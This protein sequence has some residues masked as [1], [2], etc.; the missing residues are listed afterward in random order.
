M[1]PPASTRHSSEGQ[2]RRRVSGLTPMPM[3]RHGAAAVLSAAA[4]RSSF[5]RTEVRLLGATQGVSTQPLLTDSEV[6]ILEN[7]RILLQKY[8]SAGVAPVPPSRPH[9]VTRLPRGDD[10]RRGN[11]PD[12]PLRIAHPAGCSGAVTNKTFKIIPDD[13]ERARRVNRILQFCRNDH[14]AFEHLTCQMLRQRSFGCCTAYGGR[15]QGYAGRLQPAS[16]GSR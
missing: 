12:L 1:T 15:C 6:V 5:T 16:T 14:L 11:S 2:G 9:F 3:S 4:A 13:G 10:R 8:A 7:G